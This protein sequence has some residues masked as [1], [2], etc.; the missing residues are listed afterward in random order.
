M[1][2]EPIPTAL[3]VDFDNV[4][5]NLYD[6]DPRA[7]LSF[8]T[9]PQEWL[10]FF[11]DGMHAG[12]QGSG[13]PRSILV[14]RCYLNPA[15]ALRRQGQTLWFSDY[16]RHF[17][18]AAFSVVDCPSLTQAGKSAADTVMIMDIMDGLRHETRFGEFV[19]MS[20]DADFTPVLLR[21]R[22]HNRRISVVTPTSIARAY[23]AAADIVVPQ[24]IFIARALGI[25]DKPAP[26]APPPKTAVAGPVVPMQPTNAEDPK[27][28]GLLGE[29]L[30]SA[31]AA[32]VVA[33]MADRDCADLPELTGAVYRR[34]PQFVTPQPLDTGRWFGL[35]SAQAVAQA[36]VRLESGLEFLGEPGRLYRVGTDKALIAKIVG[37]TMDILRERGAECHLS[38]LAKDV[39]KRLPELGDRKWPGSGG[40]RQILADGGEPRIVLRQGATLSS[41]YASYRDDVSHHDQ[42]DEAIKQ[43]DVPASEGQDSLVQV[44]SIESA[45]SAEPVGVVSPHAD[46][47]KAVRDVLRERG[48]EVNL[49]VIG[50]EVRK[51]ITLPTG[52]FPRPGLRAIL[53]SSGEP[54]IWLRIG[55]DG[56]T[57]FARDT[58]FLAE[59]DRS[60]AIEVAAP[61]LNGAPAEVQAEPFESAPDAS[62]SLEWAHTLH[63][64]I[65]N[66]V[67]AILAE[68]PKDVHLSQLS[69]AIRERIPAIGI[70]GWPEGQSLRTI[71]EQC[72]DPAIGL[73]HVGARNTVYVYAVS[74]TPR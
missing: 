35:G 26:A 63:A 25:T 59:G 55:E 30:L 41:I 72:G 2:D 24:D 44:S 11:E 22:A 37:K 13:R 70:E 39:R 49:A 66:T 29:A 9:K 3:Y 50:S 14:R 27:F 34:F 56:T 33:F 28:A 20:G 47:L 54:R 53:E 60:P 58:E 21:L 4:F 38:N 52:K 16:R 17:A 57:V 31:L 42:V 5:G 71:L 36:I 48:S 10:K 23:R 51:R 73:K 32:E 40:L 74:A 65:L 43:A 62:T 67:H 6:I 68:Q 15:G 64:D 69:K 19:V 7:G 8:A 45:A 18:N 46:I 1:T 61:D 12:V